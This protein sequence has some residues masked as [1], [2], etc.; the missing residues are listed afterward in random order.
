MAAKLPNYEGK[1]N[2]VPTAYSRPKNAS[3]SRRKYLAALALLLLGIIIGL[4]VGLGIGLRH[5]SSSNPSNPATQ[6]PTTPTPTPNPA[7]PGNT[8]NAAMTWQPNPG[9]SWQIV[10]EYAL[11]NT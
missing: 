5:P 4:G 7:T 11:N 8:T 6:N 1:Q 2:G 9:A 3:F 10:L